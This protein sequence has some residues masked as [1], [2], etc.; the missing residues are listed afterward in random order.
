MLTWPF[1]PLIKDTILFLFAAW[2]FIF[3]LPAGIALFV[4]CG[5]FPWEKAVGDEKRP[6][7]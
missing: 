3:T 7:P 6:N 5:F 1:F 4:A 2:G